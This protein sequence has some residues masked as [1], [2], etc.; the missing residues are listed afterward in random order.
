MTKWSFRLPIAKE[1]LKKGAQEKFSPK[2]CI[3]IVGPL[4][5]DTIVN[6]TEN[7]FSL[8]ARAAELTVTDKS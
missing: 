7:A 1:G 2:V 4:G 6:K 5:L 3:N 8:K